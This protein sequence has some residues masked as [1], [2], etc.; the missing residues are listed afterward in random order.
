MGPS[1]S[2]ST[3]YYFPSL[4]A[5]GLILAALQIKLECHMFY[6]SVNVERK[7]GGGGGGVEGGGGTVKI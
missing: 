6:Y 7:R 5:F 1:V 3:A 2:F 4:F